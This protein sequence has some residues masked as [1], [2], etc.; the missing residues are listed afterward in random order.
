VQNNLQAKVADFI[1][2]SQWL[3]P[4]DIDLMFPLVKKLVNNIHITLEDKPDM[5][6]W[7][8]A[9][10]GN[11]SLKAAF[12]FK[13][14]SSPQLHWAKI[15]WS[16]DI[17]PSK[18]LVAWRLMHD[19]LP[20]DIS[21]ICRGCYLPSVCVCAARNLVSTYFLNALMQFTFG[22]GFLMLLV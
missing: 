20:T 17:P 6:I 22:H 13:C 15:V 11:L 4:D 16:N 9:D 7:R 3:I 18:S 8:L 10:S 14:N 5:L 2:G 1:Q 12:Q 19:K 21:L